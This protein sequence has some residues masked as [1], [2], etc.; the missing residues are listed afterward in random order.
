MRTGMRRFAKDVGYSFASLAISSLVHFALRAFLARY[1]GDSDLGLYTLSFTVYSFGMLFGAFGI[2]NALTKYVAEFRDDTPR[3][4]QLLTNGIVASFAIGCVMSLLLYASASVIANSFFDMPELAA[5]LRIVSIAF[6]FIATEKATLGFLNGLR[7]MRLFAIINI[8]QNI[9]MVALTV[10][11]VVW[12]HGLEGAAWALV[13]PVVVMSL[14][15]LFTV[16]RSMARPGLSRLA[17]VSAAMPLLAFGVFV[18]LQNSIA[19]LQAHTDSVMIGYFMTDADVGLYATAVT[20]SQAVLLPSHAIQIVTGPT[21]AT[22]WGK[23]DKASIENLV[24]DT[25]RFTAAFIVPIAFAAIMLGPDLLKLFFGP[26]FVTATD[27]LRILLIGS[28]FSATW[29]GLASTLSSTAYVRVGFIL[30]GLSWAVNVFLNVLL[31]PRL[32]I[33]GAAAATSGAAYFGGLLQLYCIQRLVGV[34]VQ[35]KWLFAVALFTG[36]LGGGC[37]AL[38]N[39]V[40]AY[41]C[42]GIFLVL[43]EAVFFKFFLGKEHMASI[44]Q[45]ISRGRPL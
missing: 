5:L 31:V 10:V 24:D 28:A 38:A 34:R 18:V 32:G 43:F 29:A 41:V 26:D 42:L 39:L 19:F 45:L 37:Y 11:L 30:T 33:T 25:L 35:W 20:L 15:S 12:G 16:R 36:L 9:L 7:Q 2:G 1:L 14:F 23:G 4:G 6:P 8:L 13:V 22:F 44:K 3:I 27:S 40:S 21:M 17:F